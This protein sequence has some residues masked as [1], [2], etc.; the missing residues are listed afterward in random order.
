MTTLKRDQQTSTAAAKKA[1][2]ERDGAQAMRE[3]EADKRATQANMARLRALRLAKER[4]EAQAPKR[5][6]KK[7]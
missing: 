7:K 6:A 2:R 1:E 3:Y 5:S 4:A